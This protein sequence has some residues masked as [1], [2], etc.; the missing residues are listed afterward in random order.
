MTVSTIVASL[1]PIMWVT[2][3]PS[4]VKPLATPVLGAW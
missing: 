4:H 1:L 2:H 3:A